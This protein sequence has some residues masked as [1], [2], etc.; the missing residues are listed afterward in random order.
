MISESMIKN[1]SVCFSLIFTFLMIAS[2]K[3]S[4]QGELRLNQ[5]FSDH[6]VL[7]QNQ[8]V[9]F[10]GTYTPIEKITVSGSWGEKSTG[11]TDQNG[12]W[13]LNI[14]TPEAGG[15]FEVNVTTKDTTIFLNDVLI[16]EVWLA[17]GQSNMQM[18]VK[19][20]P[21]NDPIKNS[22]EEIANANYPSIRMFNAQRNFS[23]KAVDSIG[24]NWNVCSPQ[25]VGEFSAT[26]YFFARRLHKELNIPI[27]IIHSSWGGTVA[28]AWTSIKSI[29][30]LG[31]FEES[32]A[33]LEDTEKW[34]STED[35]YAKLD[36]V[37][38]PQTNE[39]WYTIN[40]DDLEISKYE[41]KDDNW[42]TIELPNR[43]DKF[44][45]YEFDGVVWLRKEIEIDDISTD[46]EIS[47]GII[48]DMDAVYFNG[49]RIGGHLG[50]GFHTTERVYTVSKDLLKK[51][52][53]T[54][55][56]R[57]IDVMGPGIITGNLKTS[58]K[59]NVTIPLN[60]LWSYQP[61]AEIYNGKFYIYDLDNIDLYNRPTVMVMGP[62][63]PSVLYNAMINPLI[64]YSIKGAIWYQG[65]SNVGRAE[66]YSKLFPKMISDWRSK[67]KEDFPFYFVQ[68][69]PYNYGSPLGKEG[70]MDLRNAQRKSL[71]TK[72]T[73]MVVTMDIGNFMN[74]HP[75]NKQDVGNRLAALALANDYNKEL[76]AAGPLYKNHTIS[77]NKI[78][79]EFDH[80]GSG[81][82]SIHSH[83]E[84][85][86]I[87]GTN[88][89]YVPAEAVIVDNTI[90]LFA[91][92]VEKPIYARYA[93]SDNGIASL[94][95]KEGLPASTFKTED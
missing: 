3:H 28:E 93:W 15:P 92:S 61:L 72:N 25:S 33:A 2:C 21:P 22:E 91:S 90:E 8:D 76:V 7:Q 26:A 32:I 49:E 82:M 11:I 44:N 84:G 85:F 23:L 20:W 87:S 35:W 47:L 57:A 31:D 13:K 48:D 43:F 95:N 16:G 36:S 5:L 52:K 9:A 88:K 56:I 24:G 86:E 19:G 40:F 12:N 89:K 27:G 75:A 54:I 6:M 64:P 46:Y 30:E 39:D 62:N 42:E 94:Y 58:N 51:G 53:N 18:P 77:G 29:H 55:A 80:I 70:S 17:S 71:S 83:L 81:L 10:W 34:Q 60:G 67:W 1:K 66:Q 68:I 79:L 74:I 37:Q 63:L 69:A 38:I 50:L 78:I 65:E 14:L 45:D 73:G 41:F 4:K 59:N